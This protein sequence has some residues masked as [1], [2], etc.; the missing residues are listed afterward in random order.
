M[1]KLLPLFSSFSGGEITPRLHNRSDID[2]YKQGAA[3]VRNFLATSHGVAERRG[4]SQ[5]RSSPDVNA[6]GRIRGFHVNQGTGFMLV[7]SDNGDL[8]IHDHSGPVVD[9]ADNF[10]SD[11]EFNDVDGL[12][13]LD[14]PA[15]SITIF[16]QGSVQLRSTPTSASGIAQ[17]ISLLTI[18]R[19][20]QL[21]V[22]QGESREFSIRVGTALGLDDIL[23]EVHFERSNVVTFVATATNHFV[24]ARVEAGD[25]FIV[26]D[27][28]E[29]LDITAGANVEITFATTYGPNEV[30]LLQTAQPSGDFA[31]YLVTPRRATKKL[32]YNL[33]TGVFTL[34]DV[35]FNSPPSE[36]TGGNHPGAIVFFQGRMWLAGTPGEPERLWASRSADF[37]DF[38]QGDGSSANQALEFEL[39]YKG[40][41]LWMAVSRDLVI[42]T[43]NREL[44]ATSEGGVL[45]SGDIQVIPQSSF[46]SEQIQALPVG[47]QIFYVSPDGRKVRETSFEFRDDL[48]VSR[49]M[50]FFSE[51]IT[52]GRRIRGLAFQ[53][54]PD[55]IMWFP[56]GNGDMIA[57]T[58]ERSLD[59]VGWH[60][61][62]TDG[63]YAS[64]D[65]LESFGNTEMWELVDRDEPGKF[66]LEW[67][68]P[69]LFIDSTLKITNQTPSADI[70]VP[71][72][73]NKLVS[74]TVDGA[75]H[76]DVQLDGNGVGTL[77][78][79]FTRVAVG[80][81]YLSQ[82]ITLPAI[83]PSDQLTTRSQ[84]KRWIKIY[85]SVVESHAP[86]INGVRVP[87]RTPETPMDTG[88]PARTQLIRV[89]NLGYDR[90]ARIVIEEDLP[91][92]TVINGI[93]GELSGDSL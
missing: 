16:R 13:W 79:E 57:M 70:S 21:T 90:D 81:S 27:K 1:S 44:I 12:S 23:N 11:P 15:A 5:I 17:D 82:L 53:Q 2:A 69:D 93:F 49:D 45:K 91:V 76:K 72:L 43:E 19:T 59:V 36:W 14:D 52:K 24:A 30:E 31:M 71:H 83:T 41:I 54:N 38:D 80:L 4:G 39:D 60:R 22:T 33:S 20:Y 42:G 32:T 18:G 73:K 55:N 62:D 51:H 74:I 85:V 26:I 46:G 63:F 29:L 67:Y 92:N 64:V 10:I 28:M 66:F 78:G 40:Q 87:D 48:H 84:L 65:T 6:L 75:V 7:F 25:R 86:R 61:H 68:D 3:V 9:P 56:T 8:T 58:F 88:E 34:V 89:S 50:I 77:D 35:A 37:E 47:E